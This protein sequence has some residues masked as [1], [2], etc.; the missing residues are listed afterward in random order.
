MRSLRLLDM[1]ACVCGVLSHLM[2][3]WCVCVGGSTGA[4]QC[5]RSLAFLPDKPS[6]TRCSTCRKHKRPHT[7]EE[8]E[9]IDPRLQLVENASQLMASLPT[10]SHH[11]APLLS[12][13]S[14]HLPSSTAATLL[15]A[16]PSTIRNA[17]RKDH[18]DSDLLQQKYATGVKR[19]KLAP[20]RVDQLC[21]F[22]A[23]AC[24]TKSG[25]K[26]AT[27]HQYTTDD[28][29]YSAYRQSIS[30][31]VS[32][33]TFWKIKKWMRVRRAG[34][35]HGQFDCSKCCMFNKLQHKRE[36]ELT[37]KEAH[38]MRKCIRHRETRFFNSSTISRCGLNS[39]H[40]SCSC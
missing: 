21:D 24:P 37:G 10:H 18:S 16:A 34:R 31:P 7:T 15:H 2:C 22:V 13:L 28:S 26:S 11:R 1:N 14:Q 20:E 4:L 30:N 17:K 23:A 5:L 40:V 6:R 12:A 3:V 8:Q 29:L 32:F 33:N 27:L 39:P 9:K 19:Q 25:E 36:A 38:E 35:Y